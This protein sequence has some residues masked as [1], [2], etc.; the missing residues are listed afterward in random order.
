MDG[1]GEGQADEMLSICTQISWQQKVT[2]IA[3]NRVGEKRNLVQL[4][5]SIGQ[6]IA[7][8]QMMALFNACTY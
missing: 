6:I 2:N 5:R 4:S 7:F 8:D 1:E 3:R